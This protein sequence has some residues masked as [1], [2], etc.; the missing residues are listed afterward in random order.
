MTTRI[1]RERIL[2]TKI[3]V[4]DQRIATLERRIKK[5]L[6]YSYLFGCVVGFVC[7]LIF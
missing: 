2:L 7:G 4:C 5:V 3:E 1:E 6:I